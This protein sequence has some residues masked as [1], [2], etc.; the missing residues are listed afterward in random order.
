VHGQ[1]TDLMCGRLQEKGKERRRGVA[2]L[3]KL[4][5]RRLAWSL[6]SLSALLLAIGVPL[7]ELA[8]VNARGL[9]ESAAYATAGAIVVSRR[10]ENPIGWLFCALGVVVAFEFFGTEYVNHAYFIASGSLPKSDWVAWATQAST[11]LSIPL[12]VFVFLLFPH[13]RLLSARWRVAAWLATAA[14]GVA[15]VAAILLA[16]VSSARLPLE[17]TAFRSEGLPLAEILVAAETLLGALVVVSAFSVFLRQR[18]AG[19]DERQQLKWFTYAVGIVVAAGVVSIGV[20]GGDASLAL[21]V[22][23]A[24][25][26]AA[27]LAILRYRLYDVD[28][29]INRTLVYGV[30]TAVLGI[31]YA[32]CVFALQQLL[33]PFAQHSEF[34]VAGS[35]LAVAA[36]FRP[37]RVRIQGLINRRFYRTR[38]DTQRTLEDFSTRVREKVDLDEL[39]GELVSVVHETMQPSH[40]SLWMRILPK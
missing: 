35:T 3:G 30:L 24:I 1:R 22:T 10:P 4:T 27:G 17:E 15:A 23:P 20:T 6:W 2:P 18:R 13:G 9:V 19:G 37:A 16:A 25:P 40:V 33:N 36:L 29:L 11:E 32:L 8:G 28:V 31:T 12:A 38:Y 21:W 5:P 39:T 26:M 7:G 14:G 34:A